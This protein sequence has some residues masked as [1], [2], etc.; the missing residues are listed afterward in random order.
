MC[1]ISVIIKENVRVLNRQ[2]TDTHVQDGDLHESSFSF[3]TVFAIFWCVFQYSSVNFTWYIAE[4]M[5]SIL[6]IV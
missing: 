1:E 6:Y 3:Q 4:N 2:H 5:F